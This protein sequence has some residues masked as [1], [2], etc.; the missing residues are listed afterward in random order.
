LAVLDEPGGAA[1]VS[2]Q[3]TDAR[4]KDP[5]A[6]LFPEAVVNQL[7][8]ERIMSGD[9]K[10]AIEFMQLNVTAYP[11][12]A[13]A[14]DSLADAYLAGGQKELALE[15]AEKALEVLASTTGMPAERRELIKNSAEQKVK[16]LRPEKR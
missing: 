12:S 6:T 1:K 7:G 11:A 13:N 10:G 16:Q 4:R 8:Y 2:A 3:L 9:T 14:Y 15:N 5:K